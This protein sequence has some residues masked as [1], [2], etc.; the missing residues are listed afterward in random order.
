MLR[1]DDWVEIPKFNA[2]GSVMEISLDTIKVRNWDNTI[3]FI[4]TYKLMEDSFK[5]LRGMIE[6]GSRRINRSV[7]LD[8][9]SVRFLNDLD[10]E[11]F[12]KFHLLTDYMVEKEKELQDYNTE[13][14]INILAVLKHNLVN[15]FRASAIF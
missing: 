3:I 15:Y 2:D 1:I 7:L 14:N 4:P 9:K 12:K 13:N 10:I 8:Q 5:N 6:S 11:K